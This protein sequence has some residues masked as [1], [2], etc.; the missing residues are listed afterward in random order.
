MA[1]TTVPLS[2]L[3]VWLWLPMVF[4]RSALARIA[5]VML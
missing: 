2:W 3:W 1:P 4:M 5:S